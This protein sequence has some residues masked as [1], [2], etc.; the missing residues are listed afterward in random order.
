M[1]KSQIFEFIAFDKMYQH[2]W[3]WSCKSDKEMARIMPQR[4][5]NT[6]SKHYKALNIVGG[7]GHLWRHRMSENCTRST[8]T[9]PQER[10]LGSMTM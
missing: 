10:L 6:V 3:E 5:T 2:F 8:S 4:M 1:N 7:S 9:H